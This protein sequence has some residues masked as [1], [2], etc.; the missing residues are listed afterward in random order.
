MVLDEINA[1]KNQVDGCTMVSLADLS[2][3][4]ILTTSDDADMTRGQLNVLCGEAV[5]LL[6][7][8]RSAMFGPQASNS[9][10]RERN[11]VIQVFLRTPAGPMDAICAICTPETNVDE[12]LTLASACLSR[13]SQ[14]A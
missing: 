3:A 12:F 6:P 5:A 10:V 4:M 13:I 7:A 14:N 11:G 9:I 1:L 8:D 2:S